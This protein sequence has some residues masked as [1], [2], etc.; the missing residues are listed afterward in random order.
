MQHPLITGQLHLVV[1]LALFQTRVILMLFL[2]AASE[3]RTVSVFFGW[4]LA[5]H[6]H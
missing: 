1:G 4:Y 6:A 3:T 5:D 2:R